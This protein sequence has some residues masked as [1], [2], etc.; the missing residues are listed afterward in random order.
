M[1]ELLAQSLNSAHDTEKLCRA[2]AQ[3]YD[4]RG[5]AIEIEIKEDKQG[6]SMAKHHKKKAE[7]QDMLLLLNVLAHNVL[8]WSRNRLAEETPQLRRYGTVRLA[9][10]LSISGIVE[11]DQRDKVKRIIL[12]R[13]AAL[14]RGLLSASRHILLSEDIVVIFGQNLGHKKDYRTRIK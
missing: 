8:V 6:F 5:G 14:A 13:A 1:L 9:R 3:F 7:A 2:Y 11:L 10:D 12:N 4:K